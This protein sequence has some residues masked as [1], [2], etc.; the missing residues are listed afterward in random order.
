MSEKP[1]HP[2][3]ARGGPWLGSVFDPFAG[4]MTKAAG[5]S[6]FVMM[7][8]MTVHILGRKAGHPVPGAF[9]A[10]EQLMVIVFS[11]P[12][13]EVGLRKNH[14]YFELV[15]RA[16]SKKAQA[17]LGLVA[18]G[19]GVLLFAPLTWKAWQVAWRSSAI[20]EYRQGIIDFPIWPFR[21]ALAIGLSAFIAQIIISLVRDWRAQAS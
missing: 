13:A 7:V 20:G 9:E 11:F 1:A 19:V 5:L 2:P 21:I 16:L 18:Q 4:G 12:L 8:M 17:I 10:S 15:V 14:I 6:L 3:R